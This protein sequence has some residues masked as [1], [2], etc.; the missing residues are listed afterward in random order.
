[1][2]KS[3]HKTSS[4]IFLITDV[5]KYMLTLILELKLIFNIGIYNIG[6]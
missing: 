3:L 6:S 1:M 4:I 5:I 2:I